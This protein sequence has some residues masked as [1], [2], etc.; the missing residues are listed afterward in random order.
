MLKP[1]ANLTMQATETQQGWAQPTNA[2]G[3]HYYRFSGEATGEEVSLCGRWG[4]AGVQ[5]E[6]LYDKNHGCADHCQKCQAL[7]IKTTF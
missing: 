6:D 4:A 1:L 3:W 2:N 5:P 7:R